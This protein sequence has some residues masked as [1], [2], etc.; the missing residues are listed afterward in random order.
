MAATLTGT[1][2]R[3]SGVA[4]TDYIR[5]TLRTVPG[6]TATTVLTG[7]PV[8][9]KCS[10]A[11]LFTATLAVGDYWCE[12]CGVKPFPISILAD[13]TYNLAALIGVESANQMTSFQ[14]WNADANCW[15]T[16]QATGTGGEIGLVLTPDATS[17][18]NRYETVQLWDAD[19]ASWVTVRA[20]G[21]GTETSL[22]FT[23]AT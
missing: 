21:T 5:F 9:A 20:V 13:A 16:V 10:T 14:L 18:E 6:S 2:T 22:T 17:T 23:P 4:Y 1:I 7:G 12:I 8:D 11:G 15:V 3:P 19:S